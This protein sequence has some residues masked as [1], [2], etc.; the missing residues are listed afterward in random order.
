MIID[1]E[2]LFSNLFQHTEPTLFGRFVVVWLIKIPHLIVT[3][4][5]FLTD[6]R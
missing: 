3:N 2:K 1:P 4:F 6:P 5:A